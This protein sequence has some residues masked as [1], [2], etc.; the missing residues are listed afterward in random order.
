MHSFVE[1]N[2]V[3]GLLSQVTEIHYK[4]PEL[5]KTICRIVTL[6]INEGSRE[7]AESE[8]AFRSEIVKK[9]FISKLINIMLTYSSNSEVI[10]SSACLLSAIL[11]TTGACTGNSKEVRQNL[12][13]ILSI[14]KFNMGNPGT[15]AAF[16][17]LLSK[18]DPALLLQNDGEGIRLVLMA[19]TMYKTQTSVFETALSILRQAT[20]AARQRGAGPCGSTFMFAAGEVSSMVNIALN[21]ISNRDICFNA[22]CLLYNILTPQPPSTASLL[23]AEED[24]VFEGMRMCGRKMSIELVGRNGGMEF[25]EEI[26]KRYPKDAEMGIWLGVVVTALSEGELNRASLEK[27]DMYHH[28]AEFLK[29]SPADETLAKNIFSAMSR[30]CTSESFRS[31]PGA[32]G[33]AG[34]G[35]SGGGGG[36]GD[37]AA[38]A[39]AGTRTKKTL[40]DLVD[41]SIGA[42]QRLRYQEVITV[43]CCCVLAA[44][45]YNTDYCARRIAQPANVAVVIKAL[46]CNMGSVDTCSNICLIVCNILRST[47]EATVRAAKAVADSG[48]VRLLLEVLRRHGATQVAVKNAAS[49]LNNLSNAPGMAEKIREADGVNIIRTALK[50]IPQSDE[51]TRQYVELLIES[52]KK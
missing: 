5:C 20:A 41:L 29:Q 49:A 28:L 12:T 14:F 47:D 27:R 13:T 26:A 24:G 8:N 31:Q 22:L 39:A 1:R 30:M 11:T 16:L 51:K 18:I 2:E 21:F 23:L 42:I 38:A 25:V 17:T 45:S 46:E 48:G 9:G 10:V 19:V 34:S 7:G 37:G 32:A 35:S 43:F 4:S 3:V 44:L 50:S 33:T 15:C 52:I 6:L 40:A 36:G